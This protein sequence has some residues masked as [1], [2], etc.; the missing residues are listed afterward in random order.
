MTRPRIVV[1]GAS[2]FVGRH[3]L[4]EIKECFH[5]FGLARRPQSQCGIAPHPNITWSQVDISE[6]EPVAAV[7]EWIRGHGPIEA[8]IH[9]AAHYDFTGQNVPEYQRT[10][11]D[12]VRHI[13]EACRPLGLKRF[14]F[15]SSVAAC[16][17]P[18][19]GEVITEAT[20]PHADHPYAHS[21]RAGESMVRAVAYEIPTCIVRF[22]ALYSDWC[23]YPPLFNFL[24]TWVST[25]WNARMIG[26]RGSFAIPYLHVRCAVSFLSHLLYNLELPEPGEVFIA[27]PD[28]AVPIRDVFE[29][30]TVAHFGESRRPL[31]VPKA[32]TRAWLHLQDAAGK[33][34]G[35]RPFDRPWMASYLDHQLTVDASHTRYR[36]GWSNRPR[37]NLIRRMPFLI[38]NLRT[39]P[40]RW[41]VLNRAAMRKDVPFEGLKVQWLLE[42][43]EPEIHRRQ[44]EALLNPANQERFGVAG[45]LDRDSVS[46]RVRRSISSLGCTLRTQE[47]MPVGGHCRNIASHCFRE[48]FTVEQVCAAFSNLGTV[49]IETLKEGEPGPALE[50]IIDERLSMAIQFG[51]DEIIDEFEMLSAEGCAP[52]G[53]ARR[54]SSG[55]PDS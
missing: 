6:P 14:V 53:T 31:F 18:A 44:V 20:P 49:C 41:T 55:D 12:G 37:F 40:L 48:G 13:L 1:T 11:I 27:S 45:R 10:N 46:N 23:E 7:F 54:L 38:D 25:G 36:L 42:K 24:R 15:A 33:A 39:Q 16:P 9:L 29:A 30:A 52:C 35:R 8:V 2:G 21:K 28:G 26:G 19:R 51:I 3:L 5:V 17:F 22:A 34:I 32:V 47:M 4:D 43:R 50:R